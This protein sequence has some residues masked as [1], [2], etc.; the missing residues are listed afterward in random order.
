MG[1]G[2]SI[3][4]AR[5]ARAAQNALQHG[6]ATAATTHAQRAVN[7][8]PQNPDLWFTLAY[9]ARLSGKYSFICR[10]LSPRSRPQAFFS[11]RSFRSGANLRANGPHR[12]SAANFATGFGRKSEERCGSSA[13]RRTALTTDPKQALDYLQRSEAVKASPRTE[14]LLARAY[15]RNGD[16]EQAHKMLER[17]RHSA[18]TNPE[19]LRAVA[20]YYRD[21]GQY[22]SAIRILEDLQKENVQKKDVGT[23]E[24]LGYSYAL[25]GDA[26]AAARSYAAAASRSPRDIEIQLSAA[27]AMLN[28][29]EFDKATALLNRAASLNPDHYRVYALRGRL[30]AAEHRKQDA[31]RE[32]EAALKHLPEG[33]AEGVLYPISLRVDLAEVYRDAGDTADAER[34]TKDAASEISASI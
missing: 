4:V 34:V 9:A 2:N 29:G 23:L 25:S 13:R 16:G 32:Y 31:I 20:S 21:T 5:E 14:L 28:A 22:Q 26:R 11:G 6:D 1:W 12:R 18:P 10:G 3:E 17:A 8:A 33:V 19:V 30:D 24:E 7:A 27:Q 15:Q